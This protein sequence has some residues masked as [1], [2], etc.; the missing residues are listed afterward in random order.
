LDSTWS[1]AWGALGEV[2]YHLLP[3]GLLQK[4][5]AEEAFEAARRNDPTYTP[6]LFHLT[7]IALRRNDLMAAKSLAAEYLRPNPDSARTMSMTLMLGCAKTA[8]GAFDWSLPARGHVSQVM[9]AARWLSVSAAHPACAEGGYRAVLRSA[10]AT[11]ANRWNATLGLQSLLLARGEGEQAKAVLDSAVASGI[12]D[13][14]GLFV[15]DAVAGAGMAAEAA[16]IIQD[17]AGEYRGMSSAR[18]WYLG[19]WAFHQNE[20]ERLDTIVRTMVENGKRGRD[21][22]SLLTAVL[23]PRLALLQGD[24]AGAEYRLAHLRTTASRVDLGWGLWE[25][26]ASERLL[27][28]DLLMARGRYAEALRVADGFDQA[29]SA[30][31]LLYLPQSLALRARAAANLGRQELAREFRQRLLAL[32]RKD[33]LESVP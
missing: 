27:L 18:L 20:A 22:D 29:Q 25:S 4:S 8:T 3:G 24:S 6:N 17:L 32:G 19:I 31:Y 21:P 9:S 26:L 28:A 1:A 2:Y 14:L 10:S 11:V 30:I 15:V 16:K 23:L 7:E 12:M 5:R 33:L 13:A